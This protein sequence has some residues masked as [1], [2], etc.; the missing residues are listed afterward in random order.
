MVCC[1]GNVRCEILLS[2]SRRDVECIT[3]CHC[4]PLHLAL[5]HITL[6]P[7]QH[8]TLHHSTS[9]Q[10]P[11][12][13]LLFQTTPFHVTP[14][15][16]TISYISYHTS[17]SR[18]TLFHFAM[19][20]FKSHHIGHIVHHTTDVSHCTPFH[21]TLTY[22]ITPHSMYSTPHRFQITG[23]IIYASHHHISHHILHNIAPHFF[24]H[25]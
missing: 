18:G 14:S 20:Y 21:I 24:H 9:S 2:C 25:A 3:H 17:T 5:H 19:P 13:A 22:H 8:F 11:P 7:P 16:L 23:L 1:A 4:M 10:T 6:W 12:L 15:F